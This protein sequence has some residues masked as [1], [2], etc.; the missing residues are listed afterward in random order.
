MCL[1]AWKLNYIHRKLYNVVCVSCSAHGAYTNQATAYCS[2]MWKW[3]T[4]NQNCCCCNV[5]TPFLKTMFGVYTLG[6]LQLGCLSCISSYDSLLCSCDS[7][8]RCWRNRR[9]G[10]Y[11]LNPYWTYSVINN[12]TAYCGW[13]LLIPQYSLLCQFFYFHVFYWTQTEQKREAW[14]W[15]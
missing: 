8:R 4:H 5:T 14:E 3:I 6:L 1:Q 2:V 11:Q 7:E 12:S 13:N 10:R 15:G 9:E